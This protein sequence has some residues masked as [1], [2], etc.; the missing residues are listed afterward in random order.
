MHPPPTHPRYQRQLS[1][2]GRKRCNYFYYGSVPCNFSQPAAQLNGVIRS[3][4]CR[5][6]AHHVSGV[7]SFKS[8]QSA[9]RLWERKI[10]IIP[11]H[12]RSPAIWIEPD[13]CAQP[14]SND[15]DVNVKRPLK[16]RRGPD[17]LLAGIMCHS[18][19]HCN[20]TPEIV[21]FLLI[22]KLVFI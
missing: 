16:W 4:F 1:D 13:N 10:C 12:A 21:A 2:L 22:C 17:Y 3:S 5:R 7:S 6:R 18:A 9:E 15:W 19:A 11:S 20:T 8:T 14:E